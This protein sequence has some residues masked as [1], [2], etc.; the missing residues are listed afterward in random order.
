MPVTKIK[1]ELPIAR[2]SS[3]PWRKKRQATGSVRGRIKPI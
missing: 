3:P 2:E 1:D